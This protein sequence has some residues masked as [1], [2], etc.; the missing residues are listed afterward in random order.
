MDFYL[1]KVDIAHLFLL[2][3]ILKKEIPEILDYYIFSHLVK[4]DDSP[5]PLKECL[6]LFVQKFT[7]AVEYQPSNAET[8]FN[9][10]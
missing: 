5:I 2:H 6:K 9:S 3:T 10:I 8:A 7:L 1:E 4:V